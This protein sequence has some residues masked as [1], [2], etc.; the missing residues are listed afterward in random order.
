MRATA[1]LLASRGQL[2]GRPCHAD[3]PSAALSVHCSSV[4]REELQR[5]SWN[6]SGREDL[7][8]L[9][10]LRRVA[11]SAQYLQSSRER[12]CITHDAQSCIRTLMKCGEG[13]MQ[14]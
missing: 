9:W 1:F 2:L 12:R 5:L 10:Q 14:L 4:G 13:A 6:I 7:C 3:S 8:I 11:T